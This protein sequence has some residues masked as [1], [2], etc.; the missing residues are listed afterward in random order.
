MLYMK[1]NNS[2]I[3]QICVTT[4]MLSFGFLEIWPKFIGYVQSSMMQKIVINGDVLVLKVSFC[5]VNTPVLENIT[6]STVN[7]DVKKFI[8]S[9][10]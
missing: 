7:I 6:E 1:K 2:K 3:R 10:V 4:S 8:I 5:R 9:K